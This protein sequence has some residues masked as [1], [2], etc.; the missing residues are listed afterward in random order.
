[1]QQDLAYTIY[2]SISCCLYALKEKKTWILVFIFNL[3]FVG[4]KFYIQVKYSRDCS[5]GTHS[6]GIFKNIFKKWAL[7]SFAKSAEASYCPESALFTL[8]LIVTCTVQKCLV[9]E[10]RQII[11]IYCD[12]INSKWL[13]VIILA[14]L[15]FPFFCCWLTISI[16]YPSIRFIQYSF[17]LLTKNCHWET[18]F[19]VLLQSTYTFVFV[20]L[21]SLVALMNLAVLNI[22]PFLSFF[23]F[24]TS[25]SLDI[26][27]TGQ[28]TL[29]SLLLFF[30]SFQ[31]LH[32]FLTVYSCNTRFFKYS[33][34]D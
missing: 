12:S 8:K 11:S 25:A 13:I 6:I 16:K 1:M 27:F 9:Q 22:L 31:C 2:P 18:N 33:L 10:L 23:A 17:T 5:R 3:H 28:F 14:G 19:H 21:V 15:L 34:A 30:F 29:S 24:T 32:F 26:F 7:V 20:Y 4:H